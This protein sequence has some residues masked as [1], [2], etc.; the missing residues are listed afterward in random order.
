M[1]DMYTPMVGRDAMIP[2]KIHPNDEG[3]KYL[4]YFMAN[5]VFPEVDLSEIAEELFVDL[6]TSDL[7]DRAIR[8]FASEAVGLDPLFDNDHKTLFS[9]DYKVAASF[10]I[11]L[12]SSTKVMAYSLTA[13]VGDNKNYP[14]SWVL[15]GSTDGKTWTAID[16]RSDISFMTNETKLYALN[17][18]FATMKAYT[19]YRLRVTA[20]NGGDKLEI[21]EWQL[22]GTGAAFAE[23][24]MQNGGVLTAQHAGLNNEGYI[25]LNDRNA[26]TKYCT[27]IAAG[28]CWMQYQSAKSVV[29]TGYALTSANDAPERD[30]KAW[31]LYGSNNGTTWDILDVRTDE[32]F[33]AR[34]TTRY[35]S[36]P[37][38]EA[39]TYYKLDITEVPATT[40]TQLAEWQLYAAWA[41][42]TTTVGDAGATITLSDRTLFVSSPVDSTC[43][44]V[45]IGGQ[46]LVR[47]SLKGGDI[48]HT[49]LESGI[50]LVHTNDGQSVRKVIVK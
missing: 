21:A 4:A 13:G 11:E 48:F 16:Q 19:Q 49:D 37:N 9:I 45:S 3:Y 6:T 10:G 44:I 50:Y 47:T 1:V 22:H 38:A 36:F 43:D 35:F 40:I 28:R 8:R 20:N 39:Y 25:N 33:P 41:T 24:I 46:L 31:T 23:S 34:F 17:V 42:A 7:T 2:D 5:A 32:K 14:K 15:E 29:V 26:L 30:P 12:F 18:S 27:G